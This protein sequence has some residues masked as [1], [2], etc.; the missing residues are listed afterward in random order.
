MANGRFILESRYCNQ[1]CFRIKSSEWSLPYNHILVW[2]P[3][4]SLTWQND[5]KESF[6]IPTCK[7]TLTAIMPR[8]RHAEAHRIAYLPYLQVT[9][10][11]AM[12][13]TSNCIFQ[14]GSLLVEE[15][16]NYS[17]R[18]IFWVNN[19][20][21]FAK[22]FRRLPR[23]S[24]GC[25]LRIP[26]LSAALFLYDHNNLNFNYDVIA[27]RYINFYFFM[28]LFYIFVC[29]VSRILHIGHKEFYLMIPNRN[30]VV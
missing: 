21:K 13:F 10:N 1:L 28:N 26:T 30:F 3:H 4:S 11:V 5:D 25:R 12:W 22:A 24:G 15:E 7:R 29:K 19:L 16:E 2:L 20:R 23:H 6:D 27:S 9:R 17:P 8:L 14:N 18:W